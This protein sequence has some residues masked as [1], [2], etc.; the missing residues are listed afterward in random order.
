MV[1]LLRMF[2]LKAKKPKCI[3]KIMGD[4]EVIQNLHDEHDDHVEHFVFR[5]QRAILTV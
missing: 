4:C 3:C 1:V 2:F 5:K